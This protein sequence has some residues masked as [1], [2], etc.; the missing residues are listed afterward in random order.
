MKLLWRESKQ[1]IGRDLA[2]NFIMVN[3]SLFSMLYYWYPVI[4]DQSLYLRIGDFR[5]LYRWGLYES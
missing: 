4:N 5:M 3:M 2:T 1:L